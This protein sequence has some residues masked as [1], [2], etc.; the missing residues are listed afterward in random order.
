MF[1]RSVILTLMLS[2]GFRDGISQPLIEGWDRA[3]Q[4][5][6]PKASKPG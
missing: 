6:E 4:G 1:Y 3:P 5:K 2:F